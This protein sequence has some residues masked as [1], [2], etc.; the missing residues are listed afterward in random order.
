MVSSTDSNA[1]GRYLRARRAVARPEEAGVPGAGNRRVPG[2][3]REEVAFLAGVSS[4]YYVR[5]EQGRDRHPSDQVL[6]AIARGLQLDDDG[7]AYLLQLARPDNR[8]RRARRPEKASDSIRTLID[9]W[10]LTPAYVHGRYMDI[11]AANRLATAL[12]PFLIPGRNAILD[13]FTEP[14]MRELH[15]DWDAM[16]ARVVPYLRSVAGPDAGDPRL[17]GLVGELSLR[18]DRFRALWARHDVRHKST[19]IS[20]LRH[21]QAGEL[22][23]RYEKLLIPGTEIQTLVTYHA[24]PGSDSEERLRL[25]ASLGAPD[26]APDPAP[27]AASDPAPARPARPDTPAPDR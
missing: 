7:T 4:D 20:L 12:S 10:P 6:L 21:P 24:E 18:S 9:G 14:E 27:D 17:T 2:L 5:L 16:T 22:E 25:L 15:R 1:L 13:A 19:G 26:P 8:R 11:L 3:R 23:L